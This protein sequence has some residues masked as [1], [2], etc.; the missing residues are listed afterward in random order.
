MHETAVT[1]M[2]GIRYPIIAAPMFLISNEAMVVAVG[3]A[4][5][6]G[7]MPALNWRTTDAFREA[8]RTI[9]SRT[10]APFGVNLIM[11]NN[12]R[13]LADLE[14][15][16]EERVPLIITSLGNPTELIKAAHARGIK[17]FCDVVNL[18]HAQ[19]AE[20]AGADAVIAVSAGAGGHAGAISPFV[21][22]PY[23]RQHLSIPVIAAG[24]ISNGAGV[25]GAL[26]LGAGAA[27]MG[28]R[29]IASTESPAEEG[30]KAMILS[31]QPED[32]V[33]TP[34]VTGH[35]ANFL[36]DSLE[37]FRAIKA[38]SETEAKRWRDCWSAGQGVGLISAIKPCGEIV[39]E[40][41]REY[42]AARSGLPAFDATSRV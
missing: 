11:L 10:E 9:K 39:S 36:K 4:G 42:E 20:A 6:L 13:L 37:T 8:V 15:C 38:Q 41:M 2:L 34:E 40:L 24:G 33:Y 35:P 18:R 30:F 14:V 7:S 26:A 3:E 16:L 25:A 32:I 27:Y 22:V 28:T 12:D 23:L 29:F 31:A 19:K 5:G 1:R 17:V 21:L